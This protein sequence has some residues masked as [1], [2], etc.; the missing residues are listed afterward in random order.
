MSTTASTTERGEALSRFGVAF[1]HANAAVRR[2]RGRDTHRPEELSYA[3]ASLLFGLAE[4]GELTASELAQYADVAPG[5][6]TQMLDGLE[7][8]GLIA[9]RGSERDRR[10]VIVSLTP[11]GAELVDERRVRY[12]VCWEQALT[13]FSAAEL[14]TA[15]RVLD[16]MRVMFDSLATVDATSTE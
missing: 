13:E 6:A 1:K 8:A 15:A 7:L 10:L 5:T 12:K 11:R 14:L 2:L 3:Q 4:S 9:R 16:S